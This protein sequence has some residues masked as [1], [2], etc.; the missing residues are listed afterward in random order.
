MN[1]KVS[2]KNYMLYPKFSYA[3][4]DGKFGFGHQTNIMTDGSYETIIH[5]PEPDKFSK[6]NNHTV[7]YS[8]PFGTT[9]KNFN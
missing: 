7:I 9:F 1:I 2:G 4:I 3:Q 5:I 8:T 6:V